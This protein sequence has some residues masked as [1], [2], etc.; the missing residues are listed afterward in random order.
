[1]TT[2]TR[3]VTALDRT[4]QA[5]QEA[6]MVLET[7]VAEREASERRLAEVRRVDLLKHV[8]GRSS[9]DTA[10]DTTR[11]MIEALDRGL[12]EAERGPRSGYSLTPEVV[13]L[14]RAVRG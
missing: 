3:T 11:R 13:V 4:R 14:R 1:M 7:L 5:R 12:A 8:T 2:L 9:L 6:A 10:I